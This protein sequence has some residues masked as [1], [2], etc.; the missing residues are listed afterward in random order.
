MI[1]FREIKKAIKNFDMVLFSLAIFTSLLGI[2]VIASATRSFESNRFVIVQSVALM[3][4]IAAMYVLSQIDY[5]DLANFWK[6]IFGVYVL[7]LFV[8]PFLG[9]GGAETGREG[10]IR[11]NAIGIGVQPSEIAKIGFIITLAKHIS[12][13]GEDI[14]YIKNVGLLLLHL[15]VPVACIMMQPDFGTAVVFVFIFIVMVF[16]AGIDWRYTLSA[17]GAIAVILP[18]L[19]FFFFSQYQ[20]D[21]ILTFLNPEQDVMGPGYQ[22]AQAKI[23]IGSGAIFGKGLFK[24]PQNQLGFLPEKQTDFIFA[25]IGEE[26]G[27]VGCIVVVALLFGIILRCLYIGRKSRD[28]L[29]MLI[30]VGVCAY[31]L[32]HTVENICMNIG[33]MPVKGIPLPF[34]SYGGS[35]LL[36]CFAAMGLVLNVH[37]H[38]RYINF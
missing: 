25:V 2:L 7:M 3:L 6:L 26:L 32:F 5:V 18:L 16:A 14:N 30:C 9:I 24:G 1:S 10:W 15:A 34:L 31:L 36:T 28:S 33:L 37:M 27:L 12:M 4:G 23:A 17:A 21:R 20:K 8:T 11:I 13:M 29:G 22:V 19:Y 35:S 38:R